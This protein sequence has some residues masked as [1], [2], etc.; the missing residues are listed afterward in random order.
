VGFDFRTTPKIEKEFLS[1]LPELVQL[2]ELAPDTLIY[3]GPIRSPNDPGQ[4]PTE[5]KLGSIKDLL[6][7]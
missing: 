3:A 4:W 1:Y 2:L 5:K 6:E 7:K